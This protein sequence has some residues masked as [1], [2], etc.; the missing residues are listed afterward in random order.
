MHM[1]VNKYCISLLPFGKQNICNADKWG[2]SV[3]S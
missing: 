1:S 2:E 3:N